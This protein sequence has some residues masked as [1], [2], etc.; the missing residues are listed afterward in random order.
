VT[1]INIGTAG[2]SIPRQYAERFPRDGTS[3][4]RYSAVFPVAEI[5]SSFHRPHRSSTWERWR[6]SVPA[7]FRFSVKLPKEITHQRKLVD[8]DAELDAFIDQ[9]ALLHDKLRI[10]LVQLPP[11]LEFDAN[12]TRRF[13][14]QLNGRCEADIACEPRNLS[15]FTPA[16]DAELE[17][18]RVVRVAADPAVCA[19]AAVPGGYRALAY[20]RLHGSPLKYRSSYGDRI[21]GYAEQLQREATAG[22]EAWCIFDNTASSAATGD[23]LALLETISS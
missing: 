23:A 7:D 17:Q 22:R 19:E 5:N 1:R 15:W 12:V 4:E 16:A 10:L 11:K 2:W 9:V 6:D 3:L 20:W 14:T 13:F 8:C 21:G 18:L